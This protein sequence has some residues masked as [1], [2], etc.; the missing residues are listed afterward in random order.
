MGKATLK[1]WAGGKGSPCETSG[2]GEPVWS[3]ASHLQNGVSVP[4]RGGPKGE[5]LCLSGGPLS[6]QTGM[7][8]TQA[9]PP[10]FCYS[11]PLIL[12]LA[13]RNSGTF[14]CLSHCSLTLTPLPTGGRRLPGWKYS[15]K[16]GGGREYEEGRGQGRVRLRH[17]LRPA[18]GYASHSSGERGG[19]QS[20][21]LGSDLALVFFLA[22]GEEE[23]RG[24]SES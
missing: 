12:T 14:Y 20:H 23:Q 10:N 11:F 2:E 24:R 13:G 22:L 8:V 4:P 17:A 15:E 6:R 1:P 7:Q 9:H 5:G 3:S 18:S 19:S 16:P 21:S